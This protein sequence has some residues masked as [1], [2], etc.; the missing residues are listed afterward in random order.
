MEGH[1]RPRAVTEVAAGSVQAV[2][3]ALA[4]H[5]WA[6]AYEL[7]AAARGDERPPGPDVER[8]ERLDAL[9]EAAWWVGRLDECIEA[10][11]R[12]YACFDAAGTLRRA[13][14]CAL[15][16]YDHYCLKGK[17]A[18]ATGWLRRARRALDGDLEC[19][20]YGSLLV[21]EAEVAHGA[22]ELDRAADLTRAACEL[23]RRLRDPD[24]EAQA[25]QATGRILIERGDAAEGLAH[26]DEAMLF[27]QEGRLSPYLTGLVYCSLA[28][29]CHDLGDIRR[30]VEWA[31]A[32]GS[33]ADAH[34]FAV[35]PGLCRLHHADLL[36]WRGEWSRAEAEALLAGKELAET[37]VP[38]AGA[39]FAEV[40]EIRRRLG[41]LEG[42][43]AAFARAETLSARPAA[44]LALLRL[45]QGR[46]GAASAIL[47]AA[48]DEAGGFRLA[49][50]WLLPAEVQVAV[51]MADLDR[52]AAAVT[53]LTD[54]AAAFDSPVLTAAAA[55]AAGRVQLATG[56]RAAPSTLRGAIR[57]WRELDVP[58]EVATAGLLLGQSCRRAGDETGARQALAAAEALFAR[59]GATYDLRA[60][61]AL[62]A[63]AD[64]PA[65][66]S[67]REAEVLRLVAAGRSNKA[68]AAELFIAEKTVAR[69]VSNIF[70]KTGVS[71]RAAATAYA[72]E[73][74][75]VE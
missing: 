35:F 71:S 34:P 36:L 53:E 61:R 57:Q 30:A 33:W 75:L 73:H 28:S 21:F 59:L 25:L 69:H 27:A 11:E 44:G 26:L 51:A 17:R 46:A 42:A 9:A 54:T 12:A 67:P 65:G 60:A 18:I 8:A 22:G 72:F 45:A 58:Y 23:A 4:D 40:G 39:A 43:E 10:R 31:Q 64:L 32:V 55:T 6:R 1:D 37:C 19:R 41:D 68:I 24:L 66:L 14:E 15:W 74:R 20:E 52:A 29:A 62:T 2:R 56:D 49:R 16:L 5:D 7:A 13:G 47:A 38:N 3:A 63:G 50:A 48:L 70:A